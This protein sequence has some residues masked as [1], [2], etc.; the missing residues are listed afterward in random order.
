MVCDDPFDELPAGGA[1]IEVT[2]KDGTVQ[3]SKVTR[4]VW[5]GERDGHP[6]GLYA[7]D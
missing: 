5:A 2:K 6:I 1:E 7:L 4:Q 3:V